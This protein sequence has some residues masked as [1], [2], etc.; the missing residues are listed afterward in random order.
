MAG[1]DELYHGYGRQEHDGEI[2]RSV[3]I[4]HTGIYLPAKELSSLWVYE[5]NLF[6][7]PPP[8]EALDDEGTDALRFLGGPEIECKT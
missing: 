7:K 6:L 5:V 4:H 3:Y 1:N 8:H 2:H